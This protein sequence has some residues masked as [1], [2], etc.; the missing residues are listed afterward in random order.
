LAHVSH[1]PSKSC[2]IT[3]KT[4]GEKD[5]AAKLSVNDFI[6]KAVACALNDVPEANSAWLGEVIR[7][8]VELFGICRNLISPYT[9]LDWRSNHIVVESVIIRFNVGNRKAGRTHNMHMLTVTD[10]LKVSIAP[11]VPRRRR[12]NEEILKQQFERCGDFESTYRE[13]QTRIWYAGCLLYGSESV[14]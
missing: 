10:S 14:Q 6:L 12:R 11:L 13:L 3:N 8:C 1:S 5:K 2:L 4:L 9:V 7:Q